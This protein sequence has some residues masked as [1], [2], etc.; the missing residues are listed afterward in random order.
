[1]VAPCSTVAPVPTYTQ[2]SSVQPSRV[3]CGPTNTWSAR[4]TG[5]SASPAAVARSTACSVTTQASPT[6]IRDAS[7]SSTA[8]YMMRARGP[9][10]TSPTSVAVGATNAVASTAGATPRCLI[11]MA[12][13]MVSQPS[14]PPSPGLTRHHSTHGRRARDRSLCRG[15]GLDRTRAV[16][17]WLARRGERVAGVRR[18]A[19][20]PCGGHHRRHRGSEEPGEREDGGADRAG[21]PLAFAGSSPLRVVTG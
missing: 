2:R 18:I 6:V 7:A 16:L 21:P 4:L 13:I 9:I 11:N 8:P 17:A 14:D 15:R 5:R 20:A 1:M 12:T 10:R 3:A 19:S